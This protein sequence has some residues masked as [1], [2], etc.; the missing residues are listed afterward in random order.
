MENRII[1]III[2]DDHPLFRLGLKALFNRSDSDILVV[3]EAES[4]ERLYEIIPDCHADVILL[5]IILPGDSGVDIARKL[6]AT[7]PELKLLM[8]S[9]E[10]NQH[11]I[12]RLMSIGIDGFISKNVPEHELRTAI[13]YVADG[14]EYYGRDIAR[15]I[16]CIYASRGNK[17]D[18]PFTSREKDIIDLCCKG[19]SAKDIAMKLNISLKT[20][21]AHK[22]NIFQK[23]GIHSAAELVNFCIKNGLVKL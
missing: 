6:R 17:A 18:S 10:C 23:L 1:K 16:H 5:D 20:V 13:E 19:D 4:G 22:Y 8:L 11:N 2:V 9:A 7:Y 12:E 15:I 3:G 21:S 14:G